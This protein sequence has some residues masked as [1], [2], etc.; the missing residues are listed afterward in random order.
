MKWWP[1]KKK[2]SVFSVEE[3][4]RLAIK[5]TVLLRR[6]HTEALR[7]I[8]RLEDCLDAAD[9]LVYITEHEDSHSKSN[10]L[11]LLHIGINAMRD[12]IATKDGCDKSKLFLDNPPPI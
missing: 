4:L 11:N 5:E 10:V 2:Q 7:R 3:R 1:F 9:V 8:E 12:V 6:E